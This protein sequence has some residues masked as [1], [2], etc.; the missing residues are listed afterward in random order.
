MGSANK[1][2]ASE[3]KGEGDSPKLHPGRALCLMGP[4]SRWRGR[5]ECQ[6]PLPPRTLCLLYEVSPE[7]PQTRRLP[8]SRR[9]CVR[10]GRRQDAEAATGER[11]GGCGDKRSLALQPVHT[12]P[13]GSTCPKTPVA[14]A[15]WGESLLFSHSTDTRILV[16]TTPGSKRGPFTE[17]NP[18]EPNRSTCKERR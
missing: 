4:L 11:G 16:T 13:G 3:I 2:G 6:N 17:I 8:K 7:S 1:F 10:V 5:C 18:R 12:P 14:K 15:A 9:P